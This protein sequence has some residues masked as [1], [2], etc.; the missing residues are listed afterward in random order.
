MDLV[1]IHYND[2]E[3]QANKIFSINFSDGD[4]L[5]WVLFKKNR[6][7]YLTSM[8]C[9]IKITNDLTKLEHYGDITKISDLSNKI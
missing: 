7:Y 4:R 2:L 6:D 8:S 1:F 9:F 3:F 5:Q